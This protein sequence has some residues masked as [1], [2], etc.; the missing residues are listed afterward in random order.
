MKNRF[1]HH[2]NPFK[3]PPSFLRIACRCREAVPARDRI[4]KKVSMYRF[5]TENA[6]RM[7]AH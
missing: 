5:I 3:P 4:K 1:R 7:A 6:E 2:L